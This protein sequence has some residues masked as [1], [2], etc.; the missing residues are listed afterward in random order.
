M[1]SDGKMSCTSD[2]QVLVDPDKGAPIDC[3][4]PI[5]EGIRCMDDED[6]PKGTKGSCDKTIGLCLCTEDNDCNTQYKP[7][8][9]N[10]ADQP[11]EILQQYV[12]APPIHPST[13][14]YVKKPG[15]ESRN[16]VKPLGT[17]PDNYPTDGSGYKVCRATRKYNDIG[18]S[19]LMIY[20][21]RLDR[22]VSSRPLWNAHAYNIISVNDDGTVPTP[23][24]WVAKFKEMIDSHPSNI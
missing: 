7:K 24:Q 16:L 21:D 13:G 8:N 10:Q 9:P 17:R 11:D 6:C 5:H 22:W 18:L 3:V 20:K 4:D 19:D 2:R 12:C 15:E 14:F 23:D 1:G